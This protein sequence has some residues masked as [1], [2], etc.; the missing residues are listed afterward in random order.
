VANVYR[1]LV[2]HKQGQAGR[3]DRENIQT[4]IMLG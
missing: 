1:R 3:L 4:G 2:G